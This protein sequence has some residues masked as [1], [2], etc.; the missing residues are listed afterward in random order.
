MIERDPLEWALHSLTPMD[1]HV[2]LRFLRHANECGLSPEALCSRLQR[3]GLFASAGEAPQVL[4]LAEVN[5]GADRASQRVETWPEWKRE[6]S[7]STS[8][9]QP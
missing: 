4:T 6:L 3:A 7:P 9:K 2:V 8:S 1:M 5:A